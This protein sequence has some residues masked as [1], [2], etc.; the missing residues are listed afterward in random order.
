MF[1]RKCC[2]DPDQI[3]WETTYPPYLQ[4]IAFFF[5]NFKFSNFHIL[6]YFLLTL[7]P[8][9]YKIAKCYSSHKS[10]LNLLKLLLTFFLQYP[11]KVT[12]SDYFITKSFHNFPEFL[13]SRSSKV[14]LQSF[15]IL[16][17]KFYETL[18]NLTQESIIKWA[19]S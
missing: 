17:F 2:L 7:D 5:Q 14:A 18:K 13:S 12:F 15:E 16:F 10:P 1:L 3:L 6:F 11:H 4:A 9:G 8:V 19:I